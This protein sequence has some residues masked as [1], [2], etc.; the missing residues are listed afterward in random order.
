MLKIDK[1]ELH[2]KD[3][4]FWLYLMNAF[5]PRDIAAIQSRF[6]KFN[7]TGAS[8]D[9]TPPQNTPPDH[10]IATVTVP[11]KSTIR[12]PA[13]V[14]P[15]PPPIIKTVAEVQAER[16]A[17][18][19]KVAEVQVAK[20]V[21]PS[22]PK[23]KPSIRDEILSIPI[24]VDILP[25]LRSFQIE[26]VQN[27]QYAIEHNGIAFDGSD[28][29][30]G[31]TYAA[32]ALAKNR[33]LSALVI[34]PK[35]VIPTWYKVLNELNVPIVMVV[36][37]E[38]LK[39]GKYYKS[40]SAFKAEERDDCPYITVVREIIRDDMT[41]QP[42]VSESGV[43][44]TKVTD[45][46]WNIPND[47]L[48]IFDE[49]HKGKNG[50]NAPIPTVNSKMMVWLKPHLNKERHVYGL[51]LSAT[52]TDKL[53]N[54]DVVGY[55]LGLYRPYVKKAYN[56]WLRSL[57]LD[58]DKV[59]EKIHEIIFP[60]M[61]AR[62]NIRAIKDTGDTSFKENFVNAYAYPIDEES[63]AQIEEAHEQI[64]TAMEMLR[65]R[66]LDDGPH[67]LVAILRARQKIEMIK[68]PLFAD[69]AVQWA[70]STPADPQ[71]VDEEFLSKFHIG[72]PLLR[73]V[74]I[75]V[76][77]TE[78][79]QLIT[80][81]LLE[82]GIPLSMIDHIRGGQNGETRQ[83]IIDRFQSNEFPFII[84][85]I[86]A[87][88]VGISLHDLLGVQRSTFIA[89]TWAVIDLK[90]SLGRA[91]RADALTDTLQFIVFA[92]NPK[93]EKPGV[94][95][96]ICKNVSSKLRNIALLNDGDLQNYQDF[97]STIGDL[98]N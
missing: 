78:S 74:A 79:I 60:K 64:A 37:Y 49:A 59:L 80:N 83:D 90:Q 50:L 34:C 44:K 20:H 76:C 56:V 24:N 51:L 85:N 46:Q 94:E 91:Y 84:C 61:G 32:A 81:R 38:T 6:R 7:S 65:T 69:L 5:S 8:T 93:S 72:M 42:I 30:T 86:Q 53:V 96:M 29:G 98:Q 67:P 45:V 62:M 68:V 22:N 25:K 2:Y 1:G 27:L 88:G 92:K 75:F 19:Q 58:N 57:S 52:I 33:G 71:K 97:T 40:L 31:K 35:A 15:V 13:P 12:V 14:K 4:T 10:L 18:K 11:T 70:Y 26:H 43:P 41:Q 36:N 39:N 82:R 28:T 63:Y 95:E 17:E 16:R 21:K 77:F 87:G 9:F 89:P 66:M 23:R 3:L 55:M 73:S 47:T 54:L 48:V